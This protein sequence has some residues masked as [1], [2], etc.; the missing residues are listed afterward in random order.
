MTAKRNRYSMLLAA[1]RLGLLVAICARLPLLDRWP[2]LSLESGLLVLVLGGVVA[3]VVVATEPSPWWRTLLMLVLVAAHVAWIMDVDG[4][5]AHERR[6][7]RLGD[8][9]IVEAA[10]VFVVLETR[11]WRAWPLL[12]VVLAGWLLFHLIPS[13]YG[14]PAVVG[15]HAVWLLQALLLLGASVT[16]RLVAIDR[17]E[18]A[19]ELWDDEPDGAPS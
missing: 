5:W 7:M 11:L 18:Q 17:A 1:I 10:V 3:A 13:G 6:W 12:A 4:G 14:W 8:W 15:A 2:G 16:V 9:T 19:S